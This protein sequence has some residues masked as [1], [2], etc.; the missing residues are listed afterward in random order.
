MLN[1]MDTQ[2]EPYSLDAKGK[3][4]TRRGFSR[5]NVDSTGL[6]PTVLTHN[7]SFEAL[8]QRCWSA[9]PSARPTASDVGGVLFEHG[10][11]FDAGRAEYGPSSYIAGNG[12]ASRSLK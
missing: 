11:S 9:N 12:C 10:K 7:V 3:R 2:V 4:S 6:R 5:L 1:E 8:L